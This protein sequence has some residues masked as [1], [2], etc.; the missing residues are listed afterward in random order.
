M[1]VHVCVYV[2]FGRNIERIFW[3]IDMQVKF[4]VTFEKTNEIISVLII[5]RI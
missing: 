5:V 4:V 1:F 3:K 2:F